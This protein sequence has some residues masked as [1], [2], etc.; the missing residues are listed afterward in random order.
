VKHK[1]LVANRSE[2]ACRIF[3]ACR[4][5][6]YSTVGIVSPGDEQARH[7]T[8]ADEVFEVTGY[9]DIPSILQAAKNSGAEFIHPGYGFLSE[10]PAFARA[11]EEMG[12]V[13]IGPLAETMELMGGKSSHPRLGESFSRR[14]FKVSGSKSGISNSD[15]SVCRRWWQRDEKSAGGA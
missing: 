9:L 5:M 8:Y 1:I 3:Q 12:L 6:G 13:F 2:I 11:V 4:E 7:V 14:G 15:Q 10:R